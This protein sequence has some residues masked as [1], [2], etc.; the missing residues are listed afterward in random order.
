M[1]ATSIDPFYQDI[2]A[3]AL[4]MLSYYMCFKC[5]VPY[6]GGMKACEGGNDF[7]NFKKEELVCGKCAAV[8]VGGG[9][10]DCK[11]HGMDFIEYKCKF[12]CSVAQWF[13][14]GNTHFCDPCHKKQCAGDYVS[15]KTKDQLPKCPGKATCPLKIEHPP[16]GEEYGLGCSVCR[17][18]IENAKDF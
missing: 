6:Y 8:S 1:T 13:C 7:A 11:T 2:E 12:C 9:A 5:S 3:F 17:N 16:N 14:W 4:Y 10:K 15:R 18:M